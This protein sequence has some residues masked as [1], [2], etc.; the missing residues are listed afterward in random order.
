MTTNSRSLLVCFFAFVACGDDDAPP[1]RRDA[2][3]MACTPGREGCACLEGAMCMG[4]LM[5]DNGMCRGQTR[6]GLT[7][8]DPMARSCEL[9]LVELGGEVL[10]VD[11]GTGV[12]G[13]HLREAPRNALAFHR[14]TDSAF[15]ATSVMVRM[16]TGG[17]PL[18]PR[19]E[20]VRCFDARGNPV[21]GDPVTLAAP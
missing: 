3:P 21:A 1:P 4:D 2:G 15:E 7:V 11:Y 9:L 18:T 19:L 16:A 12:R 13:T 6:S 20:A 5:C 17:A 8:T 10:G 14:T